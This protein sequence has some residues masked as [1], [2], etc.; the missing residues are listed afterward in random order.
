CHGLADRQDRRAVAGS[1]IRDA[2]KPGRDATERQG[3]Q[4]QA[5][6][7]EEQ[8][9]LQ[10]QQALAESH[11]QEGAQLAAQHLAAP[12]HAAA[13]RTMAAHFS[14]IMM[15]GALVLPLVK[16]GMIDASATRRPAMPCTRSSGSTTAIGSLP[17]LQ[18]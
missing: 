8:R 17:I 16:V 14:P 11:L 10:H 6:E 2:L 5:R 12:Y 1:R 13:A 9:G 15:Q 4:Q 18:V 7:S 3:E